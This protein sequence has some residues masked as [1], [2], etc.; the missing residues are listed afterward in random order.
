M[1]KQ[2]SEIRTLW[3]VFPKS[4]QIFWRAA[5]KETTLLMLLVVLQGAVSPVGVWI[6]K[7]V[8]DNVTAI[9]NHTP[10]SLPLWQLVALWSLTLFLGQAFTPWTSLL[11]GNLGERLGAYI[12]LSLIR[13]A[14]AIPD[15][16]PFE[17]ESFYTDL[18]LLQS[19]ASYK[20]L[21]M[22]TTSL[23]VVRNSVTCIGLLVILASL[24]WWLPLLIFI[25]SLP[26]G[27]I[28]HRLTMMNWNVLEK[29]S[30]FA[31]KMSYA[32]TVSLDHRLA[33]ET[34]LLN[35][36]GYL[37]SYYNTAFSQ[38]HTEMRAHRLRQTLWPL[39][40]MTL[41]L[42]GQV[43]AF[44][45]LVYQT[46][47]GVL[48]AGTIV[49]YIQSLLQ[50][51]F[52]VL[53]LTYNFSFIHEH[54]IFF[55]K[56]FLFLSHDVQQ[57]TPTIG[58]DSPISD[59]HFDNV[60]FQYPGGQEALKQVT[61]KLRAGEKVAIVGENGA[62]KST[63]VK[64]LTGLYRPTQGSIK[65]NDFDLQTLDLQTWRS[66]ISA[67]FQDFGCYHFTV[68]ENIVLGD[69]GRET[70]QD[71]VKVAAS[72]AG[73]NE[74]IHNLSQGYDTQ[75]GKQFGGTEFS[76]GQW[77]KLALARA[78]YRDGEMLIL[79]EPSASL[80]SEAEY[81]LFNKLAEL[82]HDRLTLF[83]THQLAS[84]RMADR[85]LVL[86]KGE[87]IEDGTHLE[88]M[89]KQGVYARLYTLQASQFDMTTRVSSV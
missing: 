25:V 14:N 55:S 30:P 11:E 32:T 40:L 85:I 74:V 19:Q 16:T 56:Y 34:R 15:L 63:L 22:V 28:D 4:I 20:P 3:Q 64:L 12:N 89:A 71:K 76:G 29:L 13:K 73:L 1:S 24:S 54:L 33:K 38:F 42:G 46:S 58:N 26:H 43:A 75:L 79:D 8:V 61:L 27:I 18:Q 78:F 48:T 41:T 21:H 5:P 50:L 49:L 59:I 2:L 47:Q 7:L 53:A 35:L 31:R 69:T 68:R 66:K 52:M 81:E 88:L 80:D 87:L 57:T 37:E 17:N 82:S 84:V 10:S 67:V 70:H 86:Q 51:Q 60:S 23:N 77:Q 62:G 39:P 36:G 72:K 6:S 65:V 9:A 83:I 45:W 44:A